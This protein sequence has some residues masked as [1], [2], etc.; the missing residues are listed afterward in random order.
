MKKETFDKVMDFL[1]M[2]GIISGI[3]A[4]ILAILSLFGV[5]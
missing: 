2:V 1:G 4:A 3:I 5:L